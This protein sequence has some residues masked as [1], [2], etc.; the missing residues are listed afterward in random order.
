MTSLNTEINALNDLGAMLVAQ[1]VFNA[2]KQRYAVELL[3]NNSI[4]IKGLLLDT[5]LGNE[6]LS[7]YCQAI[8][9]QADQYR[10]AVFVNV[11]AQLLLS[12][13]K[14]ALQPGRTILTLT[15][16]INV[17]P[18]LLACVAAYK[19][20]GFRFALN[21]SCVNDNILPLLALVGIIRLDMLGSSL[22]Q[23]EHYKKRYAR[24]DLLWLAE[25]VETEQQFAACKA[26][27]CN[28]FQGYFLSDALAVDGKKI[29][30][31]ALKLTEIIRCLFSAEPDINELARLLNDEPA[32][33]M[34]ILKIA[35][36]PLYRKT[37][38]VSSVKEMVTRLGLEL[39]RKW[40]LTYAVL[41]TATAAAAIT[42]LARAYSAQSIA[43][44]WQRTEQ[45]CQQYFLA[46]LISGSDML[47]GIASERLLPYLNINPTIFDA[48]VNNNG[49]IAQALT[50]VR[51]IER[52]YALKQPVNAQDM[53]YLNFYAAELSQI[54]Q[55]LAEAGF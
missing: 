45:Q 39:V 12:A 29:E 13:A 7:M 28:L 20:Q 27:G 25:K 50:T 9:V 3:L 6:Q 41:G 24:P 34:G 47:F 4:S 26:L 10:T 44:H 37:R 15:G 32:I 54:Q 18:A 14:L 52:S 48:I 22:A 42:V 8:S 1:P 30:P 2:D 43:R 11:S 40:V 53:P 35:N 16:D 38:D 36:S 5:S 23:V 49:P 51:S 17:T 55:R 31:G 46:A 19:Q 33:V 21:N